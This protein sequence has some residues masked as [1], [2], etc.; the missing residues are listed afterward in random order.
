MPEPIA[1]VSG[2]LAAAAACYVKDRRDMGRGFSAERVP[3]S[4]QV[5]I[6]KVTYIERDE[7][8][9][10]CGIHAFKAADTGADKDISFADLLKTDNTV[11]YTYDL[12]KDILVFLTVPDKAALWREPFLD[13]GVR[14]LAGSVAYVC[15]IDTAQKYLDAHKD[16]LP[17]S[18]KDSFLH[19]WN[20]GRCGSTLFA[21]LTSATSATV[22]L[23]EP[24]WNDRLYFDQDVLKSNPRKFDQL[25]LLLHT[26]DFH[27]ARTLLPAERARGRVIYSLNP[28][29][30]MGFLREPVARVFPE[31]K[32]V[33]MYRDM[34]KVI[35]SF[36][37]IF[38][39]MPCHAK[40]KM[41]TD[42]VVGGPPMPQAAPG[43]PKSR[44]QSTALKRVFDDVPKPRNFIVRNLST[45]W[46]DGMLLWME[47]RDSALVKEKGLETLTLRMDEFV[48]KDPTKRK[49]I[50]QDILR[51]AG[52]PDNATVLDS[53]L[54]V[55]AENSQAGTAMAKSSSQTG[56]SFLTE[57][58]KEELVAMCMKVP[59]LGKPSFVIPGSLGVAGQ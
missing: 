3:P 52:I 58:D 56:K 35:E 33:F 37:S 6:Y 29:G 46:C 40:A 20:T 28:K 30:N 25:L 32:H 55:F 14:K 27:L 18:S 48:N 53:A 49:A 45:M 26:Y 42:K 19:V 36:G 17:S 38:A 8:A 22:T 44:I 10:V 5:A 51:F 15:S 54:G 7:H 23:S 24:D 4:G 41:I 59:E 11:L 34:L 16:E 31:T 50:V 39:G 1:I 12:T 21:R 9:K 43:G 2:A 13:R 57:A 47:F